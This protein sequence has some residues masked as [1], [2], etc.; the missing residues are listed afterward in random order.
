M[1]R[2]IDGAN[3]FTKFTRITLS[4]IKPVIITTILLRVIWIFNS[5]DLIYIMT[6]GGPRNSSATLATYIIQKAFTEMNFG[7]ASAIGVIFLFL[8]SIYTVVYFYFSKFQQ[9]GNF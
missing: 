4:F 7:Q 2:D 9:A 6:G 5:A 8:L 1:K 3:S